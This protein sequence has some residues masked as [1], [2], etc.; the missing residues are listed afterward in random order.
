MVCLETD[1]LIALIQKDKGAI[2]KLENL[3]AV[4]AWITTTPLNAAELFKGAYLSEKVAENLIM[5]RGIFNGL[6]LLDFSYEAA[7]YYRQSSLI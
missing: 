4:D 6:E 5:I 3:L 1:F 7:E 2:E